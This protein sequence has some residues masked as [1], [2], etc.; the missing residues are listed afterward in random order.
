MSGA[1]GGDPAPEN[2]PGPDASARGD[3]TPPPAPDQRSTADAVSEA[4]GSAARRAGIDPA[5]GL[6][7]PQMVWRAIGGVRGLAESVLPTLLFA[8]S[9][10]IWQ[11]LLLSVALSVGAALVFTAWRLIAREPFG[12]AIGGLMAALVAALWA[13]ATGNAADAF[14]WGF[15]TNG[16]YGG[17]LLI[18]V[19]VGWPAVGLVAGYLMGEGTA[20]RRNPPRRRVFTWLT[21]AWVALFAARLAV[22]LP[23]YF[24]NDVA[25]LG[26][27]RI[28]MGVPPFAV[29][30]AVTWWVVRRQYSGAPDPQSRGDA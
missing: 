10:A 20:W 8:L 9:F 17:G 11:N 21:L 26:A 14:V 2:D 22:Q 19:L 18:S 16:V 30:L 28:F 23:Y 12:V 25:G 15:I 27:W 6:S 29:L 7:T 13:L 5:S 1:A 3:L 4:L 24:A